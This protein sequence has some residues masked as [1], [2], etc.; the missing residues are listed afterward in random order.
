MDKKFY[1]GAATA[2]FQIEGG[3]E[4]REQTIWDV[5]ARQEGK[6][7]NGDN[8]DVAC[9]SYHKF[10][11]DLKLLIDLGVNSYR[12]SLSWARILKDGISEI[13]EK[14]V[15]YYRSVLTK[16]KENGITPFV[17]L[18]HWDLPQC[19]QEKGGFL[20]EEFPSWFASYTKVVLD[21][22]GDLIENYITFNEPENS[23]YK[24]LI[25]GE[26]APGEKRSDKDG[27]LGVHHILLAHGL[28]TRLIRD[29]STEN[30]VGMAICGWVPV[31]V[32]E[33]DYDDAKNLYLSEKYGVGDG[34]AIYLTPIIDGDYSGEYYEKYADILPPITEEDKNIIHTGLDFI[35]MNLYS[36]Y[37]IHDG[38]TSDPVE[39]KRMDNGWYII[40][41]VI[42]YGMKFMYERYHLPI[43][44]TENGTCDN[45]QLIDGKIHDTMRV[46][47]LKETFLYMKKALNDGIDLR[48]YFTW[49]LLDNFEWCEGYEYR[50]GV[51]F[52]DFNDNQ[53]RYK[54]D[55]FYEYQKLIEEGI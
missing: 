20:S 29:Y 46:E 27:L 6:I 54:K 41:E 4:D 47:S 25:S 26:F 13:N 34:I 1:F 11:E 23:I 35:D 52:V 55:S 51:T 5:F 43:M 49:S 48:G 32:E 30:K 24:G 33:K 19:L 18:F 39:R 7:R 12:F 9:D 10:D 36:G 44:I 53:K 42:Y 15:R 28:A 17:T 40:N 14:G 21:R 38:V 50:F 3:V 45:T 31:P 37:Y 16:L 22:F 8:G 2:C